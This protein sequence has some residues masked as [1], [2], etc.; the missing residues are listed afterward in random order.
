MPFVLEF[1]ATPAW[2][3]RTSLQTREI[4]LNELVALHNPHVIRLCALPPEHRLQSTGKPVQAEVARPDDVL[5]F[6]TLYKQNCAACHGEGGKNGAAISL[7]N[8]VYLAA[9]GV[10]NVQRVTAAGVAGTSMPPFGKSAG[11]MLTDRQIAAIAKGI[12]DTWGH[13]SADLGQLPSYSS[14]IP[15]DSMNARHPMRHS[16]PVVTVSTEPA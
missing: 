12:V 5:D 16:V 9:A 3:R 11:G 10:E 1:T 7:A 14:S 15:G 6:P 8:P 13:A 4:A 2:R